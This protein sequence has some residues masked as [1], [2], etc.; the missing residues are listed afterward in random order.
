MRLRGLLPE[1]FLITSKEDC[2]KNFKNMTQQVQVLS[3]AMKW[4]KSLKERIWSIFNQVNLS[5]C[6]NT[7]IPEATVVWIYLF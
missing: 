5:N 3:I 4:I 1:K 7:V 6:S 2:L